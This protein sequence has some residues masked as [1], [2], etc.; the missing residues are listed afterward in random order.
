[1]RLLGPVWAVHITRMLGSLHW[2]VSL[3]GGQK[4]VRH[5]LG[6][7]LRKIN[8]DLPVETAMRRY[9]V[10]KHQRFIEWYL[11]PSARGRRF[12]KRAYPQLEGR[13]YMEAAQAEGK[14]V[15]L[16]VFH[17][18]MA[19]MVWPAMKAQG[20][21]NHH[22]VFRGETYA[23]QTIGQVSKLAVN[24]LARAE[25]ASGLKVI[26]HRPFF[27]FRT[28]VKL[29]EQGETVGMNGDGMMGTDFADVPF[30][31]G[32]MQ[33][34][35]GP[36]RLAAHTGAPI[37]SVYAIPDGGTRHRLIAHP[38]IC[39]EE[40]SVQAVQA[41]VEDCVAVLDQYVRKYPWEWWTWRRLSVDVNQD[42][43]RFEAKA[44]ST[45]NGTYHA[46]SP[47]EQREAVGVGSAP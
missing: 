21:D 44:L 40:D 35:T 4:R 46:P 14:G 38:P 12:V 25:E 30:L 9:L 36:A 34:P 17:F 19:K 32:A 2:L 22:H 20:F 13:E 16:L 26:Y 41:C 28:M 18:G 45:E 8:S 23:G 42:T 39:C 24:T 33:L 1:M 29:L 5:A 27:T 6:L 10:S 7:A 43:I 37:I 47:V 15:I 3:A 11:Y 31:G